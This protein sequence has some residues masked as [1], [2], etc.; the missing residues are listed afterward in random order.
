M[1]GFRRLA[2]PGC[3]DNKMSKTGLRSQR[4]PSDVIQ[5]I[6]PSSC[7]GFF[8]SVDDCEDHVGDRIT[9]MIPWRPTISR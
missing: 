7:E 5:G 8:E 4:F 3:A 6:V 2:A 9:Q 1:A